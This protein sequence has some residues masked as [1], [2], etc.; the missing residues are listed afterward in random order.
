M[1]KILIL[2]DDADFA[3]I[4]KMLVERAGYKVSVSMDPKKALAIVKN[5]DLLLL[6][7]I[8]VSGVSGRAF[9]AKMK[10]LK[11]KTPVIIVSGVALSRVFSEEL[12]KYYPEAGFIQ[13][14]YVNTELIPA[15]KEKIG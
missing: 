13:K 11:L 3:E 8:M 1:N 9:L 6:D 5:Y 7:M 2:E 14:T 12:A 15:I 4:E 10:E